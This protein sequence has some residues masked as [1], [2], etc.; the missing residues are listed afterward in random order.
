MR[1]LILIFI[2]L[3]IYTTGSYAAY[4]ENVA[5]I[6]KETSRVMNVIKSGDVSKAFDDLRDFWPISDDEFEIG[7]RQTLQAIKRLQ[8]RFGLPV[9]IVHINSSNIADTFVKINYFVKYSEHAIQWEFYFYKGPNGWLLN[10]VD[11]NDNIK[12]LFSTP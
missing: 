4:F 5:H 1:K 2:Y 6:E 10:T 11:T 9:D 3:L 7:K 12:K 8:K